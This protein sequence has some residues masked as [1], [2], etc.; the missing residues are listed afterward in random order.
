M[1]AQVTGAGETIE[2]HYL[3]ACD[4]AGGPCGERLGTEPYCHN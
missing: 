4:G 2:A 1:T 3:V